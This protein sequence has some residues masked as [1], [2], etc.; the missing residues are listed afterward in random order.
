MKCAI[1]AD[2]RSRIVA[3]HFTERFFA[4]AERDYGIQSRDGVAQ[5]DNKHNIDKRAALARDFTRRE[6]GGMRGR[7]AEFG[8]PAQRGLFDFIFEQPHRTAFHSRMSSAQA[9]WALRASWSRWLYFTGAVLF[10]FLLFACAK[11][12]ATRALCTCCS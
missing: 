8:E 1:V 3:Q 5:A 4:R 9:A 11:S 6:I 2:E 10:P 7:V 12:A